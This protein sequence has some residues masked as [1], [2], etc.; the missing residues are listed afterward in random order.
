MVEYDKRDIRLR[1]NRKEFFD[2]FGKYSDLI[3]DINRNDFR[4]IRCRVFIGNFLIEMKSKEFEE[5]FF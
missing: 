3:T 2:R 5:T 1:E 4:F